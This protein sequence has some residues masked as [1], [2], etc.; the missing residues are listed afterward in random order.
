MKNLTQLLNAP[1][2]AEDIS[3][4]KDRLLTGLNN[5]TISFTSSQ[6]IGELPSIISALEAITLN[7]ISDITS[8]IN[9]VMGYFKMGKSCDLSA[10][11]GK[12][13]TRDE[14]CN[15]TLGRAY[16]KNALRCPI[17]QETHEMYSYLFHD[18][19]NP[20]NYTWSD[21]DMENE[22]TDQ[23]ERQGKNIGKKSGKAHFKPKGPM[24]IDYGE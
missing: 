24:D 20:T 6:D 18:L 19:M 10:E 14:F 21:E 16:M 9:G 3:S 17:H 7:D 12:F 11:I 4:I 22:Y 5:I 15:L 13:P 1:L 8:L 2:E 23:Y